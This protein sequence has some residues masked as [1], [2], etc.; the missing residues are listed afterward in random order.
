MGNKVPFP[1]EPSPAPL[2]GRGWGAACFGGTDQSP[3][4][5]SVLTMNKPLTADSIG[6]SFSRD[7]PIYKY[8]AV[9]FK[10]L[11]YF[12]HL[13]HLVCGH[14]QKPPAASAACFV[15]VCVGISPQ[16]ASGRLT[17]RDTEWSLHRA[18]PGES[19][20]SCGQVWVTGCPRGM[21]K[22]QSNSA[23]IG[24][25]V[26]AGQH[27][28]CLCTFAEALNLSWHLGL[29]KKERDPNS[30]GWRNIHFSD[31]CVH[32]GLKH[33]VEILLKTVQD[34]LDLIF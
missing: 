3:S 31:V 7:C 28:E 12:N 6:L 1:R 4:A 2:L 10:N 19:L 22:A 14:V 15:E 34:V 20:G 32:H 9:S 16:K 5:I 26:S 24:V 18:W 13:V 21:G 29:E 8:K 30:L 17:A 27:R 11:F 25:T 23:G 33:T